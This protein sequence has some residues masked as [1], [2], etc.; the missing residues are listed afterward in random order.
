M[1]GLPGYEDLKPNVVSYTAA[2]DAWAKSGSREGA[3]R[4]EAILERMEIRPPS[5]GVG[6]TDA[7]TTMSLTH[8]V[9]Q[10]I[11]HNPPY[12]QNVS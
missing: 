2:I 12:K 5:N 1:G 9:K 4:A 3:D 10:S 8:G 7:N 11:M 6:A